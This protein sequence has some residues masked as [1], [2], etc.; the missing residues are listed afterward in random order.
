MCAS[1]IQHHVLVEFEK[2][3]SVDAILKS[4]T[5]IK[6]DQVIPVHSSMLYFR[7]LK[8]K[9]LH[10]PKLKFPVKYAKLPVKDKHFLEVLQNS[11]TAAQQVQKCYS[12]LKLDDLGLRLRFQTAHQLERCFSGIFP[13]MEALPFGSSVNGFGKMGCDLDLYINFQSNRSENEES[14]L[15]FQ[16]KRLHDNERHQCSD[17]V[18]IIGDLIEIFAPG[19]FNV[20]KILKARVPIVKFDHRITGVE[21]DLSLSNMSAIYMSELLYIYGEIDWR[22]R[23]VIFTIRKWAQSQGITSGNPGGYITNFSLTLLIIFY[24]QQKKVLPTLLE[25]RSKALL[26]DLRITDT[27]VDCTFLRDI[28]M[29]RN[30][31]PHGED[32][33]A[34][35]RGFFDYYAGFD[36]KVD[37]VCL[38]QGAVLRK[39]DSSPIYICNPLEPS[40]NVSRNVTYRE[41]ENFRTGCR[42]AAWRLENAEKRHFDN[43]WGII[44]LFVHKVRNTN[45]GL[46]VADVMR[47]REPESEESDFILASK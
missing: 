34:L 27:N 43:S 9:H 20:T 6:L 45:P 41:M 42:D 36:F 38:R 3:E 17:F 13:D 28:S 1:H 11:K 33:Y 23:P 39:K 40:L 4:A 14:R 21:C 37:A 32:P 19:I 12:I 26:N 18:R 35:L 8:A 7:K 5:H 44:S 30:I 46:N 31:E 47:E 25:L 10:A 16:T 24:L 2:V 15:V 29:L 22:V